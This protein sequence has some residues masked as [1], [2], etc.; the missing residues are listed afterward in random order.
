M[1]TEF[2]EELPGVRRFSDEQVRAELHRAREASWGRRELDWADTNNL[3]GRIADL[4]GEVWAGCVAPEWPRRRA[5]LQ[6]DVMYRAG[7]LAAH[8]WTAAVAGMSKH[9]EWLAGN[10]VRYTSQQGPDRHASSA[11]L[12]FVPVSMAA[13]TWLAEQPGV[14]YALIYPA[15]GVAT[16][17][18]RP[19]DRAVDRLLGPGRASVLRQLERPATSSALALE[20]GVSLGTVGGHLAV[21]REAGLVEGSRVGH[22]VIYRRTERAEA[23]LEPL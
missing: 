8:G 17:S 5:V 1:R 18:P 16:P 9:S 23:L 12:Q 4:L 22:Q 10:A 2:A 21:L 15:R 19:G 11:G 7:M 20:L 6:R 13:G 14:D 3:A